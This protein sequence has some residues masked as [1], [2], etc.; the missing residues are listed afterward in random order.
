[1]G[2]EFSPNYKSNKQ[3]RKG[4][5]SLVYKWIPPVNSKTKN[6]SNQTKKIQDSNFGCSGNIDNNVTYVYD[7]ILPSG[8]HSAYVD[9]D[10]VD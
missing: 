10:Y 6:G 2:K 1:M 8:D 3:P 7:I 9:C 5:G 4:V